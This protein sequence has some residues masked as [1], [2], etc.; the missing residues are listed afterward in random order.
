MKC[1]RLALRIT[2]GLIIGHGQVQA[3]GGHAVSYG[4][5][6]APTYEKAF[7][8]EEFAL[9][10]SEGQPLLDEHL[11]GRIVLVQ[12]FFTSC[13]QLCSP[14]TAGLR[15]LWDQISRDARVSF[16]SISLD[17]ERDS[18]EVLKA[19]KKR[20]KVDSPKWIYARASTPDTRKLVA[21]FEGEKG[22]ADPFTHSGRLYLLDGEGNYLMSYGAAT[23]VDIKRL[24]ADLAAASRALSGKCSGH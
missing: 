17:P 19:Y 20:Y 11:C 7:R 9:K 4:E 23:F 22:S 15:R 3:Q 18:Q 24:K 6:V 10:D 12:F 8:P 13:P 1:L 5:I 14:Q 2:T 16:L 21:Q